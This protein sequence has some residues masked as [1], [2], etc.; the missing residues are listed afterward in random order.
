MKLV[1]LM[2]NTALSQE[3]LCRHGL[4]FYLEWKNRK[5]LFD[6]GPDGDFLKNAE[7]MGIDLKEVELAFLSHGHY[8]HGGGLEAFLKENKKA[9]VHIQEKALENYYS[10]DAD[11]K[12]RYIGL[13]GR[14]KD[15]GRFAYHKG[16]YSPEEGLMVFSGVTGR[17][18]YSPSNDRLYAE[19]HGR[20]IPDLFLHEQ[21][22]IL[23]EGKGFVL[24][25]G[26]AH[27]GIVNI[28]RRAQEL[29]NGGISCVV[30]GFHLKNACETVDKQREFCRELAEALKEWDC[31][32]YTCHC[33]GVESYQFLKEFMGDQIAYLAAG[34]RLEIK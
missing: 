7:A 10:H 19:V 26:C 22:L 20:Q 31:R 5:I 23:K 2:E 33:T 18:C 30:S 14:I 29:T 16:D 9:A 27:N 15:C 32:Y 13:P 25:A 3:F 6:M 17:A 34:S 4:S 21:N 11:G 1:T 24:V 12:I 8:D 28:L